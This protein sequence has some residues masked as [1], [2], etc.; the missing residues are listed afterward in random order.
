MICRRIGWRGWGRMGSVVYGFD[1]VRPDKY[2][3]ISM[4]LSGAI[5]WKGQTDVVNEFH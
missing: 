5:E 1:R 4:F 3:I 2:C